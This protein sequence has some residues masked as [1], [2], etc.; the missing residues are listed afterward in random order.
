GSAPP[1]RACRAVRRRAGWRRRPV[2]RSTWGPRAREES[3]DP[4][5]AGSPDG[6]GVGRPVR[7]GTARL[8]AGRGARRAGV[9]RARRRRPVAAAAARAA[10]VVVEVRPGA[11]VRG[12]VVVV[13]VV[14]RSTRVAVVVVA[15]LVVVIVIVV[16]IVV[17]GAGVL[18]GD[19]L[20]DRR[21]ADRHERG[22]LLRRVVLGGLLHEG[23]PDLA[24]QAAAED[25]A[26]LRVADRLALVGAHPD[27]RRLRRREA[28]EPGV[29]VVARAALQLRGAGLRRHLASAQVET[30]LRGHLQHRL[31]DV[32]RHLLRHDLAAV[33]AVVLVEHLAVGGL[34]P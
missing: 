11:A 27:G 23:V 19:R 30:L 4:A 33:V 9:A 7:R 31:D 28:D 22:K 2:A 16:V 3:P 8:A 25:R 10:V 26:A 15:V 20:R 6:T 32:A 21:V 18:V 24:G 12:P 5:P 14:G 34:D 17:I 1:G 13:I 29:A